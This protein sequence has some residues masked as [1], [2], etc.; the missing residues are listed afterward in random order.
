MN[1]YTTKGIFISSMDTDGISIRSG[2]IGD[3]EC[4]GCEKTIP[5]Q[6]SFFHLS[7]GHYHCCICISEYYE[8]KDIP[9]PPC[10]EKCLVCSLKNPLAVKCSG[11]ITEREVDGEMVNVVECQYKGCDFWKEVHVCCGVQSPFEFIHLPDTDLHMHT[12]QLHCKV[13]FHYYI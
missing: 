10:D 8:E 12:I 13:C 9:Q 7:S 4:W 5:R 11:D 6:D 1:K 3:V 2:A